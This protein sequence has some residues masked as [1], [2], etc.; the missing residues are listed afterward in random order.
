MNIEHASHLLIGLVLVTTATGCAGTTT[1]RPS[2]Q[3]ESSPAE[4]KKQAEE[5]N[6]FDLPPH[7]FI[8]GG[9]STDRI[10]SLVGPPDR[11]VQKS[12]RPDVWHYEFGVLMVA[13]GQVQYKYPPSQADPGQQPQSLETGP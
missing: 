5:T 11:T 7:H 3:E 9:M 13:D 4:T 1:N 12:G 6:E 10:R 2:E 8:R